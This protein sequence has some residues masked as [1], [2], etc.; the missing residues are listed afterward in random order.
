M[1][2]YYTGVIFDNKRNDFD[3]LSAAPPYVLW[4][5]IDSSIIRLSSSNTF[6]EYFYNTS[7]ICYDMMKIF[8]LYLTKNH[9]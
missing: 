9:L 4:P 3:K 1:E 5:F 2:S 7:K 8:L 6:Q